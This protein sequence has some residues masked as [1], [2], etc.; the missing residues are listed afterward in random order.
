MLAAALLLVV[1]FVCVVSPAPRWVN[2]WLLAVAIY[3][4]AKWITWHHGRAESAGWKH[5]VYLL[6]WPGLNAEVFFASNRAQKP[7]IGEWIFAAAK[8]AFGVAAFFGFARLAPANAPYLAG[9]IGMIGIGF[10]LHF[11]VFHLLSCAWRQAG[12]DARPLMCW[13]IASVS[14][15]EF[16]GKR[17]NAAFR[18]LTHLFL[19]RPLTRRIGPRGALLVGFLFSGLIHD[20]VISLPARGGYGGPTAFFMIQSVAILIE[21]SAPGQT[22]GLGRGFCGWVWMAFTLLAPAPLLFHRP[23]VVDVILPFMHACGVD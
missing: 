12:I 7:K 11:G 22:I 8:T 4:F 3:S 23:F 2:M 17:W 21:R 15:A 5:A 18:D 14:L 19:F 9:W 16:W 10:M 1:S 13:P 20:T 6:A